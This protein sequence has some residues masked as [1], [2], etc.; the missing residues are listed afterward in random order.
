M[1]RVDFGEGLTKKLRAY[2]ALQRRVVKAR[3]FVSRG[4]FLGRLNAD[5]GI[6]FSGRKH[7][8]LIQ[9]LIYACDK[10][11]PIPGLVGY[12]TEELEESKERGRGVHHSLFL[13]HGDS[14]Q[15][16]QL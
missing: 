15:Y 6:P 1:K 3:P 2:F 5:F 4:D 16:V 12:I 7:N 9:K 8:H 13:Y 11:L 10:V 14:D